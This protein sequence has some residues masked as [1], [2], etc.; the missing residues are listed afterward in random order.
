MAF[1][2]NVVYLVRMWIGFPS[3]RCSPCLLG[4]ACYAEHFLDMLN[5]LLFILILCNNGISP[6]CKHPD[7]THCMFHWLV[8]V[9]L[10]ILV[11]VGGLTIYTELERVIGLTGDKHV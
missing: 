6:V 3:S 5:L 9:K 7:H 10:K 8:T 1:G 11:F 2:S 4:I